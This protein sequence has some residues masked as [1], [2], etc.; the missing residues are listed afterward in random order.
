[1]FSAPASRQLLTLL[2]GGTACLSPP[3]S[4]GTSASTTTRFPQHSKF[5]KAI[6]A[7]QGPEVVRALEFLS[8][9]LGQGRV[10]KV[11]EIALLGQVKNGRV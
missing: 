8:E 2:K 5:L 3:L 1:M 4:L 10:A 9:M 11:I 6:S 7:G